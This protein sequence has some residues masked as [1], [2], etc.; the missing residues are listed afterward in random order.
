MRA[1]RSVVLHNPSFHRSFHQTGRN[2]NLDTPKQE[3]TL[4]DIPTKPK[5]PAPQK[6]D[7]FLV[8][9][10]EATCDRNKKIKWTPE[11]IE[12]PSCLLNTKTLEIEA[13]FQSYVQPVVH[14]YLTGFCITLTGIT[15]ATVDRAPKF[16][17]VMTRYTA[18]LTKLGL[19][20][21]GEMVPEK[22]FTPVIWGNMDLQGFLPQQCKLSKVEVPN[23]LR[24]WIDL[25]QVFQ[26]H[27]Q[28]DGQRSVNRDGLQGALRELGIL[29]T[30]R[31]HNGLDDT[32]LSL[33]HI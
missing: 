7:Y 11:I 29:W 23:Y 26:D 18:W 15:Q 4:A 28:K 32:R 6:F 27:Y 9:D 30:G 12:W 24:K 8:L 5:V 19:L 33:I 3:E 21:D 13:E 1:T 20:K 14:P 22:T 31:L 10:Y 25:R 17:D 16:P 2:R